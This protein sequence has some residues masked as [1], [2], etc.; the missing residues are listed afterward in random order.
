MVKQELKDML[1]QEIIE[2]SVSE[3]AAPIVPIIKKD[4]SLRLC[5]DYRRLNAISQNNVYPLPRIDDLIDQLSQAQ[6]VSTLDL[7]R[8]YWQVPMGK[9]SCHKT[10]FVT[11]AGQFN[12][13]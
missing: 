2:Q 13:H 8:G 5:V 6:F 11:P 9:A 12:L 10:A 3:W 1:D 4:G 7:T